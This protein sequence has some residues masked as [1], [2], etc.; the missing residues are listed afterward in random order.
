MSVSEDKKTV[1]MSVKQKGTDE[2]KASSS[3][4]EW[5]RKSIEFTTAPGVTEVTISLLK[6]TDTNGH[7]YCDNLTLPLVP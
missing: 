4:T 3:S 6:S 1:T 7:A 5:T 2:L